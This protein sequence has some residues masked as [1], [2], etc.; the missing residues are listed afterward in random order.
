MVLKVFRR[1]NEEVFF[2][3]FEALASKKALQIC[4]NPVF[5]PLLV[6]V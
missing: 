5:L 4:F 2:L 1:S 3:L 6:K